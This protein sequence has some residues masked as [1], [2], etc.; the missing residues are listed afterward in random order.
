MAYVQLTTPEIEI[1]IPS[2]EISSTII[3]RKAKLFSLIYNKGSKEVSVAWTVKHYAATTSDGYGEYLAFIPDWSK[4]SVAD[5]TTMCDVTNGFPIQMI[6]VGQDEVGIPI[7]GYDPAINYTGQYDFFSHLAETQPILIHAMI[8]QF[9]Q[10]VAS[11]EK[12]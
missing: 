1:E 3:R 10:N 5:N 6:E 8:I 11:W 7:M 12:R 2:I 4:T 9:G